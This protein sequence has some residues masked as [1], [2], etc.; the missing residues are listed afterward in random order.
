VVP[1][2][3]KTVLVL[4]G[5]GALGAY[6]AGAYEALCEAGQAPTWIA[7]ISIGAVNAAIIAGNPPE[8]R[9]ARLREFW[10]RVSS[11][12]LAWPLGRDDNS[13]RIFNE[14]SAAL[15]ALGGVPGFFE[16]RVPPAVL[17]PQGTPEAISVYDTEPLVATLHEL[18]DFDLLNSGAVRLSVGAVQVLSGNMKYFDT[19]KQFV[20]PEHVMASGALPPGFPPIEIDGK[21][22]WDG[23]L[24][25]NTPLEFVLERSGPRQD[26]VIFQIDLFSAKGCMPKTLFDIGQREKEIRYSSRTRFN[27]DVFR[28]MQTIRRAIRHL[29]TKLPAELSNNPDWKILD[30]ASCDAAVTIVLLIHR[31]AAYWTQSNDYEFSRFSME[32]HWQAGRDDVEQSLNHPDW[33]NRTRPEEGVKVL[34]FTRDLDTDPKER[35]L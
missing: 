34:D 27:T 22:Y 33:K 12:L 6:Q 19:A 17:M 4:Q 15:A 9:V 28:E 24:V 14:T 1:S 30:G 35:A 7:G 29:R 10:E 23:G 31:R 13:R 32:E 26:M 25:S 8:R 3:E 21:P 18:V 2:D 5:G 16:P 11:R 20:G